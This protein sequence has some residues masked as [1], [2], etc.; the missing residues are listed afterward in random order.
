MD[1]RFQFI[2]SDFISPYESKKKAMFSSVSTVFENHRKV[3]FKIVQ[4][5]RVFENL[6]LAVKLVPDR[7]ILIEQKTNAAI[8][9]IFKHC[10]KDFSVLIRNLWNLGVFVMIRDPSS[11]KIPYFSIF[12]FPLQLPTFLGNFRIQTFGH[13]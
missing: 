12:H 5:W 11:R 6:K 4:F 2:F 8:W 9:V 7:S 13:L 3:S 10:V 1:P